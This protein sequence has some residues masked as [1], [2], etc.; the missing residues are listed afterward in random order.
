M[1]A[2][3]KKLILECYFLNTQNI[4]VFENVEYRERNDFL[5]KSVVY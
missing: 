3:K 4:Y 1:I 2:K 5:L